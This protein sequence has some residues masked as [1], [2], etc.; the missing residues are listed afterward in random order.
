MSSGELL[1]VRKDLRDEALVVHVA[2]E[3]DLATTLSLGE[4]LAGVEHTVSPPA[5]IV[6]DTTDVTFLAS[7][8]LSLLMD[9]H[10]RCAGAGVELRVVAGNRVVR[11]TLDLS[12]LTP[13]LNVVDDMDAALAPA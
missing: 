2:G 3:V 8:G 9:L 11:R 13:I 7:A 12:G 1:T 5:R 10:Q 6:V 4:E